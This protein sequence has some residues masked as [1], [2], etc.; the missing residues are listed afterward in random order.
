MELPVLPDANFVISGSVS[1]VLSIRFEQLGY[2]K[3]HPYTKQLSPLEKYTVVAKN[4]KFFIWIY[5]DP[6]MENA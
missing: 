1:T 6:V 3:L 5:C 2:M 4:S